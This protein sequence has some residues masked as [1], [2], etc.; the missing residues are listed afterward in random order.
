MSKNCSWC[1]KNP[2]FTGYFFVQKLAVFWTFVFANRVLPVLAWSFMLL[3]FE[4]DMLKV[5]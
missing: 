3:S 2:Y 1:L 5:Y 4:D